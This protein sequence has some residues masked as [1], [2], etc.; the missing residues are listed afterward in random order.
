[1]KKFCNCEVAAG[2]ITLK[3]KEGI[4]SYSV[5]GF[6]LV[7]RDEE[8]QKYIVLQPADLRCNPVMKVPVESI[9]FITV[10]L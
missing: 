5:Y 1:M 10:D 9:G 4:A 6:A 3:M 7:Q 8:G 2:H